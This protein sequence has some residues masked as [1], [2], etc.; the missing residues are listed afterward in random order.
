MLNDFL[1]TMNYKTNKLS[2][3]HALLTYKSKYPYLFKNLS[4]YAKNPP[5]PTGTNLKGIKVSKISQ[6]KCTQHTPLYKL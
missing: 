1:K 4:Y 5:C 3:I 6:I 2:S